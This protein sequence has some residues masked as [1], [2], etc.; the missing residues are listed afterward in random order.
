MYLHPKALESDAN[1]DL[2]L[3]N[4]PHCTS[5]S[6]SGQ[7]RVL[8]GHHD[9]E[10]QGLEACGPWKALGKPGSRWCHR[11][12]PVVGAGSTHP[13]VSTQRVLWAGTEGGTI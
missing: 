8:L 2:S 11:A 13:H 6:F 12:W 10:T 3:A 1:L 4:D 7:M 9:N 5:V